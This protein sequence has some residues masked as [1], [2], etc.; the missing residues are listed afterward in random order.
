MR[1]IRPVCLTIILIGLFGCMKQVPFTPQGDLIQQVGYD[2]AAK[3]LH[4]L[5]LRV[6]RPV[7]GEVEIQPQ[8]LR[9]HHQVSTIFDIV[10]GT[11]WTNLHWQTLTRLSLYENNRVFIYS[12]SIEHGWFEFLSAGD[13]MRFSSLIWSFRENSRLPKPLGPGMKP[14][15]QVKRTKTTIEETEETKVIKQGTTPK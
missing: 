11:I 14:A 1:V 5:M 2:A 8:T 6:P 9:Y 4:D 12:G 7:T 10:V 3:E 13:A 15:P